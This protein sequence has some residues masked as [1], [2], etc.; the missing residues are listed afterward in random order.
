MRAP[1]TVAI[2]A[3][4]C[5]FACG[6]DTVLRAELV[7]V[8]GEPS[9][10]R[11]LELPQGEQP[12]GLPGAVAQIGERV[13]WVTGENTFEPNPHDH[14]YVP[15]AHT[16][17]WA[18]GPCGEAATI[19]AEDVH[20]V[21]EAEVWPGEVLACDPATGDV[22]V[23]DAYGMREPQT[24]FASVGC[25]TSWTEYG[26]VAVVPHD[27]ATSALVLHPYAASPWEPAPASS[28]L[29]E[30]MRAERRRDAATGFKDTFEVFEHEI[31]ALSGSGELV[32]VP[33]PAGASAILQMGVK[34]FRAS[35]DGRHVLWQDDEM[36]SDD[37][38]FPASRV[39]LLDRS[40]GSDEWVADA[41][42][43]EGYADIVEG[44]PLHAR[45]QLGR[46]AGEPTRLVLLDG[47]PTIDIPDGRYPLRPVE[48]GEKWLVLAWHEHALVDPFYVL[49]TL[50]TGAE[51]LL[52]EGPAVTSV[53]DL[54]I[55]LNDVSWWVDEQ[56]FDQGPLVRVPF[57]TLEPEL[58]AERM[59]VHRHDLA[60]GR[61][62]TALDVAGH[63]LGDLVIV[64][65]ADQ[66]EELVDTDVFAFSTRYNE[67][68][69]FGD[70]IAYAVSD[71]ERSGV[72][73]ARPA[74]R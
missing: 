33:L 47:G 62:L 38:E 30:G 49:R 53:D 69:V 27:E 19:V 70:A 25:D 41:A 16:T 42:I 50:E 63:F 66:S 15:P 57:D 34:D 24:V 51:A 21:F 35:A 73:L 39:S 28:I 14:G 7:E 52:F 56:P 65:P 4:A 44:P 48:G 55:E 9:P 54:G 10:V 32:R 72:W 74:P 31:L 23:I 58:V 13:L 8:C 6:P 26:V 61:I 37:P 12:L 64:D 18:S 17:V 45:V 68:D 67:N 5:M 20:R 3:I 2:L 36:L 1:V 22:L 29:F 60:D 59:S 43:Y 46:F 40:S 11:V 71:G